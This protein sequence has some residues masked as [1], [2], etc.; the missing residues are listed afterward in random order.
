MIPAFATMFTA[1]TDTQR[2]QT[3][4]YKVSKQISSKYLLQTIVGCIICLPQQ[5]VTSC[6]H[7]H[8][9]TTMCNSF[10]KIKKYSVIHPSFCM[11]TGSIWENKIQNTQF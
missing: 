5:P 2:I 11:L 4:E 6:K 9:A 1:S 8:A 10:N 3:Y 7:M